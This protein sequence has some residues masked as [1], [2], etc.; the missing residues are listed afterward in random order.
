MDNAKKAVSE[1]D[2]ARHKRALAALLR[3]DANRRCADCGAARPTWASVNL[4]VFV[5]LTCSGVHRSL[6]V[7]ISQVRSVGLDTWLPE[8]VRRVASVGNA[9]A[10]ARFEA[11]LPPGYERPSGAAR[12][13][14]SA[15]GGGASSAAAASMAAAPGPTPELVAFVRAK[16]VERR[17]YAEPDDGGGSNSGGGEGAAGAAAVAAPPAAATAVKAIQQQQL[18]IAAATAAASALGDEEEED[19]DDEWGGFVS[20]TSV[21]AA[22]A[23]VA[24]AGA[25]AR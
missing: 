19:D 21:E 22:A 1:G 6:G 15:G 2:S 5:C 11:R 24:A 17:W 25:A 13:G 9:R 8:Q 23:V 7:H 16:Y 18:A 4:G 14:S 10:N 12:A 3:L 20:A